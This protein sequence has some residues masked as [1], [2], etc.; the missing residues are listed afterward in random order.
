M[1]GGGHKGIPIGNLTSQ[2]FANVY[3]N[4]LDQFIKHELKV[5]HY[6]RY[7]DDFIIISQDKIYLEKLLPLLKS[8]L[9]ERLTLTLHPNKV[10]IRKYRQGTDFLGYVILPRYILVRKKTERRIFRQLRLRAESYR[11][12]DIEEVALYASLRSYL[13]VLSHAD[14]Y[15]VTERLINEVWFW[16]KE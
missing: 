9:T 14:A 13:G 7:T 11:K 16:S 2:I 10:T 1:R 12:G 5:K 8:F 3:M 4:K 6:V 15:K